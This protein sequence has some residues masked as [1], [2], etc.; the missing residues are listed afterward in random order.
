MRR[1]TYTAECSAADGPAIHTIPMPA[2]TRYV[3]IT[4]LTISTR[5]ADVSNDISVII[6]DVQPYTTISRWQV[7]L[8]SAQIFGGH[9]ASIGM[10]PIE[11]GNMQ[12]STAN[13]GTGVI[14]IL[15]VVYTCFKL[16]D[17]R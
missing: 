14:T 6:Q 10:I 13:G 11:H 12:I 2:D 5:G 7:W 8:R 15:T 16:N 4:S 3:D 1:L 9:F 17:I